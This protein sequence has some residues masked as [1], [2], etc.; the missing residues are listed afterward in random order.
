[1]EKPQFVLAKQINGQLPHIHGEE[2]WWSPHRNAGLNE[3]V[4]IFLNKSCSVKL[5]PWVL[6]NISL[7]DPSSL[8]G[9][10]FIN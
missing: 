4:W 1:M 2:V 7:Q 10:K 9:D 6:K 8:K 3:V 5:L